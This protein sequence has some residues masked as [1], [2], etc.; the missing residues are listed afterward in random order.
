MRLVKFVQFAVWMAAAGGGA[1]VILSGSALAATEASS[2]STVTQTTS[3]TTQT[4]VNHRGT[5][6]GGAGA[7]GDDSGTMSSGDPTAASGGSAPTAL[8]SGAN[9]DSNSVSTDSSNST[10]KTTVA[11]TQ[12][13]TNVPPAQGGQSGSFDK[14]PAASNT[15]VTPVSQD[16]NAVALPSPDSTTPTQP[17]VVSDPTNTSSI[18]EMAVE[19]P[20][21]PL[22]G[23]TATSLDAF[24]TT[25]LP[26]QPTITNR[27]PQSEDLAPMAPSAPGPARA[28]SPAKSN[29]ML[30]SL[31]AELAAIVVPQT[32]LL[33]APVVPR[34]AIPLSLLVLAVLLIELVVS[35]YGL[36]LRRGGFATAARSDAPTLEGSPFLATPFWLGYVELPPRLHSPIFMAVDG[37]SNALTKG[38]NAMKSMRILGATSAAC[39]VALVALAGTAFADSSA[40]TTTGPNSDNSATIDNSADLSTFNF[41]LTT[42]TNANGQSAVSGSTKAADN[43]SVN[44]GGSGGAT[45]GNGTST[46]VQNNAGGTG[47]GVTVTTPGQGSSCGCVAP[48]GSSKPAPSGGAGTGSVLGASTV[49]PA[50]LPVTGATVPVDVSAL[51]AAWKAPSAAPTTALVQSARGVSTGML[52]VAS[53]LSLLGGL[54]SAL[55]GRRKE[56]RV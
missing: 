12:D 30:G 29:G 10:V 34:A 49:A 22:H 44:G 41:N 31:T 8:T 48:V 55:Y 56:R 4:V 25:V 15:G 53:L 6:G 23:Q 9:G 50:I 47:Q 54:G 45:N 3:T 43:T 39:G 16:Q 2:T 40:I 46:L 27:L 13:Q 19:T 18:P 35:S 51:R 28:P 36:W 37:F 21:A 24:R 1:A 11:G 38:G 42:L 32:G 17:A 33:H 26:I 52:G 5:T 7:A 14:A 20:V